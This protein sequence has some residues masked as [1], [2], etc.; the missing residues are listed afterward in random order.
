MY[1]RLDDMGCSIWPLYQTNEIE[2]AI[3]RVSLVDQIMETYLMQA[4][5]RHRLLNDP[6][7]CDICPS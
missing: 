1:G 3:A 4:A 2:Q 6:H 5:E 7:P